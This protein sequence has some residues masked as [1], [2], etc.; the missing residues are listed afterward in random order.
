MPNATRTRV[1]VTVR[2]RGQG[3]GLQLPLDGRLA[4][5]FSSEHQ[6]R[7]GFLA[8]APLEVV[9]VSARAET[10]ARALPPSTLARTRGDSRRF[11][12]RPPLGGAALTIHARTELAENDTITG[13]AA[14]EESTA[15]TLVPADCTAV[16]TR[17]GIRL[18]QAR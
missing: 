8:D 3:G 6:R 4:A 9:Q 10:A 17:F 13:P 12:R 16:A 11:Q 5:R 1:Q 7:Y 2:Y 14:I 15:T 18:E